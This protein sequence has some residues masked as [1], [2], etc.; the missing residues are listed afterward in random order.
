MP[1]THAGQAPKVIVEHV[2][3]DVLDRPPRTDRR[4]VPVT[5]A[6]PAKQLQ[7][8]RPLPGEQAPNIQQW[9]ELRQLDHRRS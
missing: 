8:R 1:V 2:G 5:H 7:E 4:A 9:P 3:R 6:Q